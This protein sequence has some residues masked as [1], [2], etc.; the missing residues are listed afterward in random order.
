[1]EEKKKLRKG[2][3]TGSCSAAA[4]KAAVYMLLT[5]GTLDQ[6]SIETP[7]GIRYHAKI[8]DVRRSPGSVSCAVLKDG[9]DDPDV[10][11]GLPVRAQV[12]AQEINFQEPDS[13]T[14]VFIDG[15]EGVGRVTLSGLDQPVGNAAINRVPRQMIEQEVRDVTR[16]LDFHGR[17]QVIISV[18]GGQEVAERTFNPR[19]G[20]QGGIS[21]LGTTGI[22]EPMSTKAILD[23]ISVELSQRWELGYREVAV[24]P[25]N[26]GQSFMQ[27]AYGYDLDRSVKC[28]NYIGDTIDRVKAMGFPGMLLTGHIGKLIK[29]SGG[30]M[31]THSKE[32]D[33]RMEL[34]TAAMIRCGGSGD[35]GRKILSCKVTEE[36]LRIIREE[37]EELFQDTMEE[38]MSRILYYLRRRAGDKLSV[39]CI[40]YSSEFGLLASSE[41]A[42][43]MLWRI[44]EQAKESEEN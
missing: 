12:S 44:Q 17:I 23:T 2:F 25:G 37:S 14:Q 33:A 36:A 5:G 8:Q 24:T 32:G 27:E 7:A 13:E 20:I 38:V 35:T 22:V 26:Y 41:G 43:E 40:L 28:S 11:T 18:P 30:M 3:T 10:T 21:I 1:M 15:G 29:V 6:I 34:L 9:G 42:M 4:A 31:N 16:A 39:E 19:L